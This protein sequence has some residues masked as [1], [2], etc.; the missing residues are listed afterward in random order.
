MIVNSQIAKSIQQIGSASNPPTKTRQ[1]VEN[2]NKSFQSILNQKLEQSQKLTFSK[3]ASERLAS[4][5]IELD[6]SQIERLTQGVESAKEKGL[7]E[8]LMVVDSISLI[9]N[10]ESSTV[11]TALDSSE[12]KQHVFT[13]IDGAVLL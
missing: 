4:R 7:K 8:S 13:N 11:I 2:G 1:K 5:D 3:H 9:V 6:D 10:V 12:S